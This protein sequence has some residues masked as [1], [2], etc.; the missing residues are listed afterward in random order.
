MA[1]PSLHPD[2]S[3]PASCSMCGTTVA[4]APITW[5]RERDPRR[6]PVWICDRCAR[7]NLRGIE[8]RLDQEW[9]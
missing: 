5:V 8:S 3:G 7:Q 9:W 6:G 1:G 4:A 2:P